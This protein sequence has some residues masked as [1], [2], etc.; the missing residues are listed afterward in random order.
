MGYKLRKK[1]KKF[2]RSVLLIIYCSI[3][4]LAIVILFPVDEV[5]HSDDRSPQ[6]GGMIIKD[7]RLSVEYN[8]VPIGEILDELKDL[9][10]TW[11]KGDRSLLD[12]KITIRFEDLSLDEGMKRIL[13]FANYILVYHT[14]DT[15]SGVILFNKS[16][17]KEQKITKIHPRLTESSSEKALS[18]SKNSGGRP[19]VQE[20]I[21]EIRSVKES[22]LTR[23][24]HVG[25]K[26]DITTVDNVKVKT[27]DALGASRNMSNY[28]RRIE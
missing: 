8:H 14:G 2:I 17:T 3:F 21:P 26:T 15:L 24:N 19:V 20:H 22:N 10:N 12:E 23:I 9:N 13:D 25:I 6:R 7:G 11:F 16:D 1:M 28:T 27:K 18:L 4:M 5:A